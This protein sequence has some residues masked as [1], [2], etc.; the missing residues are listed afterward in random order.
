MRRPSYL[1]NRR[2]PRD[3]FV[4]R[5]EVLLSPLRWQPRRSRRPFWIAAA[6]ALVAAAVPCVVW[7][8]SAPSSAAMPE[9]KP[10]AAT[11]SHPAAP[12]GTTRSD[13]TVSSG[14]RRRSSAAQA[15]ASSAQAITVGPDPESVAPTA[16][17][18][19]SPR[20][21]SSSGDGR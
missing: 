21:A 11:I 17:A 14:K 10:I 1:W 8:Q 19:S 18:G 12:S 20:T 3:P 2:G 9:A 4:A 16:P 5:L 7:M 13:I 6:A 15:S